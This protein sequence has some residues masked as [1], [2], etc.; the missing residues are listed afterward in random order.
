L[1]LP[2][3]LDRLIETYAVPDKLDEAKKWQAERAK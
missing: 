2:E 3:P 1:R